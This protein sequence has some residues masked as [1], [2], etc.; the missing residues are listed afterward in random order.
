[1]SKKI[2]EAPKELGK[3]R[4]FKFQYKSLDDPKY[5]KDKEE[6]LREGGNGWWLE[7]GLDKRKG[8]TRL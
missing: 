6:F 7:H 5:I 3:K 8:R 2:T 1:M 4:K